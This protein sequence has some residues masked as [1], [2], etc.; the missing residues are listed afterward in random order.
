MLTDLQSFTGRV[1]VSSFTI[2]FIKLTEMKSDTKPECL[3][4]QF[5]HILLTFYHVPCNKVTGESGKCRLTGVAS[6][7]LN[8]GLALVINWEL[9][10]R[11]SQSVSQ[12][13]LAAPLEKIRAGQVAACLCQD[14]PYIT[15]SSVGI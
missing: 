11:W 2:H 9:V 5:C 4:K 3:L 7:N 1:T 10:V 14:S 8:W 6:V 12:S 15:A 13:V